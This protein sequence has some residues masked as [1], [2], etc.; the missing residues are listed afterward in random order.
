MSDSRTI[1]DEM[2]ALN[3]SLH[4]HDATYGKRDLSEGLLENLPS[5]LNRMHDLGFC[6]NL[7][8][9]GTGK[10]D[11]VNELRKL[12]Q[13]NIDGF[14]PGNPKWNTPPL[15]VYDII[16]CLDV[17]EHVEQSSIHYVL[18]DIN[19][20]ASRFVFFI[21]DLQ[22]AIKRLADNRN[23]HILI[24]PADWWIAEISRVFQCVAAFPIPN[25]VGAK[26]KLVVTATNIPK[27]APISYSFLMKMRIFDMVMIDAPPSS[28]TSLR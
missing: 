1:S 22:P 18:E 12:V 15:K 26:Q 19:S 27:M 20:L 8:D 21:V 17:L 23:A 3:K 9:Y 14:D 16:T 11:L 10:G 13:F 24:A 25:K 28:T 4:H 6:N 7:L 5:T 2:V